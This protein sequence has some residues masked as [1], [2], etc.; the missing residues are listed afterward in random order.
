MTTWQVVGEGIENDALKTSK[1]GG[2]RN[3]EETP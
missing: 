1:Y 2:M 3:G